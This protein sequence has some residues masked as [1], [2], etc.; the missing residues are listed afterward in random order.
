MRIAAAIALLVA[1]I[2]LAGCIKP[3]VWAPDDAVAAARY[4]HAG[5][6]EI[7]LFNV[8]NNETGGGAHAALMINASERVIFDP[9]GSWSHTD[10]PERHDVHH[11]FDDRALQRYIH[12]HARKTHHVRMYRMQVS[13][14]LA[15]RILARARAAGPVSD[16][17]CTRAIAEI[18]RDL[19]GFGSLPMTWFP[20]VFSDA[21]ALLPGVTEERVYSDRE[22]NLAPARV[23]TPIPG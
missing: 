10:T 8:V 2:A 16:S 6:A 7:V 12:Y 15:E 21:F 13:P 18:L 20:T 3:V 23:V 22:P 5:P 19:D 4:R 17:Y 1:I 14:E 11:G 9:A